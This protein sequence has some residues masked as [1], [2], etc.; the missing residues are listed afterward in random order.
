MWRRGWNHVRR[1][2]I[3]VRYCAHP[4]VDPNSFVCWLRDHAQVENARH[5]DDHDHYV[6]DG[7]WS[8]CSVPR[9]NTDCRR[10]CTIRESDPC[11]YE[12]KANLTQVGL[13]FMTYELVRKYFTPEGEKNP[14]AVRKLAAGAISGAVAQTCTYPLYDRC[15][16]L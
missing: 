7:G 4:P 11:L 16:P 14:S 6:Q 3:P 9:H 5:V 2:H 8:S 12:T 10:C 15:H 13:N 1:L